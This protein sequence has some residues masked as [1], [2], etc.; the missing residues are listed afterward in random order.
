MDCFVS[1]QLGGFAGT[2]NRTARSC[3]SSSDVQRHRSPPRSVTI[4]VV[5]VVM[6]VMVMMPEVRHEDA[7]P[8]AVMMV[9][10][11]MMAAA[12]DDE[13]RRLDIRFRG[14]GR[15]GL[16]DGLQQRRCIRDRLEQIG[17]GVGP[18]DVSR[19]RTWRGLSGAQRP[20]RRHRSQKYS[21]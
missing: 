6:M 8:V 7:P 1:L 13:L 18:H 17:E 5:V 14:L 4:V 19:D 10:V 20:E 16:I 3:F 15:G 11:M 12:D 21:A 2:K 9:V